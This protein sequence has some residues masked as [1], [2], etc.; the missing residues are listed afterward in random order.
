MIQTP[1]YNDELL[2]ISKKIK[3][4]LKSRV[5]M[6]TSKGKGVLAK[7]LSVRVKRSYGEI[8]S[9][10]FPFAR[11]GVFVE[12]GV[13][14]GYTVGSGN[15]VTRTAKGKVLRARVPK[16]WQAPIDEN[17]NSISKLVI[18]FHADAVTDIIVK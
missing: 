14:R 7:S 18:Q 15:S 3:Q 8:T 4:E 6:L 11:H 1:Q 2:G 13:G 12:K 10:S 16:D 5:S 17:M 9:M